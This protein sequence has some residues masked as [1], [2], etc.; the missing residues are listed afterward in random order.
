MTVNIFA[1]DFT[2]AMHGVDSRDWD[3]SG[4]CCRTQIS[5]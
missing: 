4:L 3:S 5:V 1:F 2:V